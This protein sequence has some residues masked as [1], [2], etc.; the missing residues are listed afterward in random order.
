MTSISLRSVFRIVWFTLVVIFL[1]WQWFTYQARGVKASLLQD[2]DQVRVTVDAHKISFRHQQ[3]NNL[4]VLFFPGGLVDPTAYVP[5][6]RG[7]SEA[8]YNLH[9][10]KMPWRLSTKGYNQ[11]KTLFDLQDEEKKFILGGHSQGGKMAAQFVFENQD[12]IDGL[13][14]LGTSHPRDID[15]SPLAIPTL[16]LYAEHDGLASVAEVK[17]NAHLLPENSQLNLLVGGNHSQ[18][19]HTGHLLTDGRATISLQDQQ[20]AT[21]QFLLNFLAGF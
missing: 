1:T 3:A 15:L 11:I 14:L 13:F 10:I 7:L 18:F 8:G 6:A 4:E 20:L 12:L 5:L 16:K 19:A 9:I 21:Q 2:S 17:Q